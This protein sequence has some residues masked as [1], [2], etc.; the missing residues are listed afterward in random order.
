M[1]KVHQILTDKVLDMINKGVAPWKRPWRASGRPKNIRG[2][3]YNGINY[4]MLSMVAEMNGWSNIWMTYNQ[5]KEKGGT[6]KDD[7]KKN[8]TCA[9]FFKMLERENAITG[10]L[11]N[12]HPMFRFFLVYNLSQVDGIIVKGVNDGAENVHSELP[13]PQ[14]IVDGY[15][16]AP[17]IRFGGSRACYQP[18]TDKIAMPLLSAFDTPEHYYATMFHEL[19]HSTGHL[20]RLNR[21]EVMDPIVFGSHDYSLEELVAELTSL[22][23]CDECGINNERTMENSAAYLAGWHSKLKNDPKMFATAAAR[24]QKAATYILGKS[25]ETVQ[26]D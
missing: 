5:I 9:Y 22:F 21:K 1:S 18:V 19:A 3:N 23:L 10:D 11:E 24:A 25:E 26:E 8:G 12:S 14:S 4:F 15:Q 13:A 20:S 6:I 17:E 2:T 7:Q 16:N